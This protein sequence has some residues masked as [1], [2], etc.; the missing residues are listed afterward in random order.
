MKVEVKFIARKSHEI[1]KG[2]Y[3]FKE[4]LRVSEDTS[5][6]ELILKLSDMGYESIDLDK[7]D[8]FVEGTNDR[9]YIDG[10]YTGG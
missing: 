5:R 10:Y 9:F 2:H 1:Q 4:T 6:N 3:E 8:V 7:Y